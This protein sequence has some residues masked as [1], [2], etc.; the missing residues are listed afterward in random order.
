MRAAAVVV[1]LLIGAALVL[2]GRWAARH[3][4][5]FVP[6]GLPAEDRARR[7]RVTARGAVACQLAG[8]TFAAMNLLL[9][10]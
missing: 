9:F 10:F 6:A 3:V 2:F 5:V 8:V 7:A 4:S 1:Q